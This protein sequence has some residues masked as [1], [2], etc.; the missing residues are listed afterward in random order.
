MPKG[1]RRYIV[2]YDIRD[3]KRLRR[4]HKKMTEYGWPMQYSVFLSDLDGMEFLEL[5]QEL[6]EIIN[7][8]EDSVA[9]IDLGDPLERGKECFTF[10]GISLPLPT[11]GPVVI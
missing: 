8:G 1:R 9:M 11:S 10:M 3:S 2:A 5:R 4:V 7:H 6:G